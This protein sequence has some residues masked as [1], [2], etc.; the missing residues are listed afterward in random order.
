MSCISTL[1][2][3]KKQND[4]KEIIKYI[5]RCRRFELQKSFWQRRTLNDDGAND[6]S[7][8]YSPPRI[9]KMARTMGLHAGWVLDLVET[10][11]DD[12]KPLDFLRKTRGTRRFARSKRTN[13]SWQSS[14]PCAVPSPHYK[15]Y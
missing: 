4:V 7:E 5:E 12:N 10:D 3:L 6:V 9:T 8:A 11:P 1:E 14:V 15:A 13:P 2:N